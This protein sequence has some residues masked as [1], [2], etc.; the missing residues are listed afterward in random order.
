MND[1]SPKSGRLTIGTTVEFPSL[2]RSKYA[3]REAKYMVLYDKA[4]W[5]AFPC[6]IITAE[7]KLFHFADYEVL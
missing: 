6:L 1:S 7:G 2:I 5:H 3:I 4:D